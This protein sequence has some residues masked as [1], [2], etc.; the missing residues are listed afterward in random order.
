MEFYTSEINDMVSSFTFQFPTGWNSTFN[1]TIINLL[2][3]LFQFPT[4]WNSTDCGNEAKESEIVSIPNGMEFYSFGLT[5]DIS[6]IRVSIPNG[7]E[8]YCLIKRYSRR[9]CV[10]QFPTGWN[11]TYIFN[12]NFTI[13]F[14]VSIPNGMEF[15]TI[16]T[17]VL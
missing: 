5:I 9:L 14:I 10:F 1:I 4:G 6:K 13:I 16:Q 8:F 3:G 17:C 15:Y 12:S 11:S 7:M 2:N